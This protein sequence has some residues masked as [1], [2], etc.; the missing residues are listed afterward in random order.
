M[1]Y[2]G[3]E[4]ERL[5]H[6]N[7]IDA[8]ALIRR[9]ALEQVGGYC[10]EPAIHGWEDYDLWCTFAE[11][12]LHGAHVREFVARYRIGS[13]SMIQL[14]AISVGEAKARLAERHPKV[15]AEADA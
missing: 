13:A 3:W 5:A 10:D 6:D 8:L 4:P 1:G 7:Y 14:T 2:Y 11:R 9:E 15:F 12:G